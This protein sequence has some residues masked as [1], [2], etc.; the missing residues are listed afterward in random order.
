MR[1]AVPVF[2]AGKI[3]IIAILVKSQDVNVP[4]SQK[5]NF[6]A[7]LKRISTTLLQ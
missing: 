6:I 4:Q 1:H 2:H 5:V 3:T 7:K